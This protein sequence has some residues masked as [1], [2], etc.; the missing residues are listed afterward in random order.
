MLI[1]EVN[2]FAANGKNGNP[3][4]VVLHADTLDDRQ[5][6]TIAT[7]AGFAETAFVFTHENADRELRFFTQTNE[8]DL[9]GHAT[10]ASWSLMYQKGEVSAGS[11]TQLT[12]AGILGVTVME[13]GMVFMEQN[14]V[15]F[16]EEIPASAVAPLVN[17]AG[18][19]FHRD[20]KP[21]IVSTGIRDLF[22][23]VK[24]KVIL[25]RLSPKFDMIADF[26]RQHDISGLH[27]FALLEDEEPVA[28]TRNFAPADGIDE[29]AATG[30]SNGALLCYLK[31]QGLLP[32]QEI[33]R[34]EQG[35]SM[36]RL[37]YI[38][39]KFVDDIVWVGGDAAAI[40]TMRLP[41]PNVAENAT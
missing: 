16:Y 41:L 25:D 12:K 32:E 9:C 40:R 8:V 29:E 30:T 2:A 23:P 5:M 3:A 28:S 19:D 6:Q 10:I 36:G 34:L 22:V 26:S 14:P 35:E 37:S 39:G 33:Y 11:Y 18:S 27:F 21:Q 31:R 20:L 1:Y 15:T 17:I 13:S 38:Y 24:E 7:Q 4:G